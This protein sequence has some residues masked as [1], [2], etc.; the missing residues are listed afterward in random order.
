VPDTITEDVLAAAQQGRGEA[1]AVIW[2]ELS[3]LVVGYLRSRGATDPEGLTSDVF[4]AVLPRLANLDGG[5][6]G[7]RTFVF[8]V[9]HARAVDDLRRRTRQPDIVEFDPVRH[10]AAAP[11]AEQEALANAGTQRVRELLDRLPPD[12]GEVL[13]LR[14]VADLDLEQTAAVMG[15]SVGS[16]KQLQRRALLA[17]RA[18]IT[19]SPVTP[20]AV[21]AMTDMT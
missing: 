3:P 15:R 4:L 5:V 17:L 16:I 10:D 12:Y 11:S 6:A 2:R 18:E 13:S 1:F 9:A 21:D 20:T 19:P 8:A 14:V 7:L